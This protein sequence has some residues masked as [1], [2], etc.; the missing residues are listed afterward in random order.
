MHCHKQLLSTAGYSLIELLV[1]LAI[2]GSAGALG[3]LSVCHGFRQEE[4]RGAAQV[5]Q[6]ASALTQTGVLWRGRSGRLT[7]Q[8]GNVS[9]SND[10]SLF[11]GALGALA[12]AAPAETNLERWA[13][14]DGVS[15]CFSGVLASPDGGGSIFFDSF[16]GRY[17]VTVRPET[18]LTAR[19]WAAAP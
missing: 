15:V 3:T 17:R 2:L 11:G 7:Y 1:V 12:P 10:A 19:T 14:D 5:W 4:A 9:L 16:A 13:T 18:G 8:R 6:A